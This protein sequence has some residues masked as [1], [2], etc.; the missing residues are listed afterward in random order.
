MSWNATK[1]AAGWGYTQLY[2][3]RDGTDGWEAAKLPME[4]R[5][6]VTGPEGFN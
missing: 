1:R 6:P 2:W 5:E 4:D 3:Y